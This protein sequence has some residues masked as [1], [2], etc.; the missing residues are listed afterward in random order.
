M[1]QQLMEETLHE[2]YLPFTEGQLREH[3][4]KKMQGKESN[5]GRHTNYLKDSIGQYRLF[6]RINPVATGDVKTVRQIEKDEGFEDR[7]DDIAYVN[8][9][10]KQVIV[11]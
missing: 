4:I 8:Y 1:G 9:A 10:K 6:D 3:F 11:V 5:L 7:G 2:T